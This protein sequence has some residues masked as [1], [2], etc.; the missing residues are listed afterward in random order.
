MPINGSE[1]LA[2]E[3]E[4]IILW[5]FCSLFIESTHLLCL[6]V[7]FKKYTYNE[8]SAFPLPDIISNS[9]LWGVFF[10]MKCN[11]CNCCNN[12]VINTVI[13]LQYPHKINVLLLMYDRL[14]ELNR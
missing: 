5:K 6:F 4:E 10:W 11:R 12:T 14:T 3:E 7:S 9:F 8:E 2:G 13:Q 1:E